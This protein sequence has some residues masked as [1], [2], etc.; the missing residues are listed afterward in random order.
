MYLC[1][2]NCLGNVWKYIHSVSPT[3]SSTK[4]AGGLRGIWMFAVVTFEISVE[5]TYV[6]MS[7]N[8]LRN[9][10]KYS[11]TCLKRPLKKKTKMVCKVNYRLMQGKSIAECSKGSILQ[12]FRSSLSYHLSLRSLFVFLSGRLRQVL[13][14]FHSVSSTISSTKIAGLLRGIWVF[15]VVT[16]EISTS[17]YVTTTGP[18]AFIFTFTGCIRGRDFTDGT[19]PTVIVAV[20]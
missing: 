10:W 18:P 1:Q 3:I 8:C 20:T 13:L 14:F 4:I 5:W 17:S 6:F 9:V 15:A 7:K 2:K 19:S 11:R 16:I 12:Y